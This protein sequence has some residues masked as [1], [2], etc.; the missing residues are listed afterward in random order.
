MGRSAVV[1]RFVMYSVCAGICCG[2]LSYSSLSG[3]AHA[4]EGRPLTELNIEELMEVEVYSASK[5]PQKISEAPSSVSIVTSDEIKKYGYRTL[6]EIL[7]SLRG[8]FVTSDRNYDYMGVRGF[9]RPGDYNT[10]VLLLVDGHRINDNI[11][12]QAF[13]GT[14]FPVD[15]DL[16]DR[17]EVIRGPGSSLYGSNAFF[18]VINVLTKKG[19]DFGG[20]EASGEAGSNDAYKARLSYGKSFENGFEAALSGSYYHSQGNRQLYYKE[21]D[22]PATNNGIAENADSGRFT[23]LFGEL[24][25]N[26]FTLQ[27]VYSDRKKFVPTAS[28]G[29][30]FNDNRFFTRE[31]HFYVDLKYEHTFASG[32][33]LVSRLSYNYHKYNGDYPY[34]LTEPGGIPASV[35][36]KDYAIG[37]WWGGEVQLIKTVFE[38]HKVVVGAEYRDNFEQD[39]GNYDVEV[40]LDD[41]RHSGVLAFYAEDEFTIFRNLILNAGVR[42]DHYSTFG[43]TTNPRLAIVYSPL[44]KTTFKL[45][46]GSAFR[47]PNAVE[48]YYK[49]GLD[50]KLNP[51]LKPE[52]IRT[53]EL[54]CEQLIG[55]NLRATAVG[56][57][58]KIKDLITLTVDPSDNMF[59]Y[60]NIGGATAKGLEFELEGKW[61]NGLSGRVS[62]TLQETKDKTTGERLTN[63]PEHLAKLN[64][65]VPLLKDKILVGLEEQFM[66]KRK[67]LK[68]DY[69]NTS[70]LTNVTLFSRNLVKNMEASVSVYNLFDY[71]YGDP[72]SEEHRQDII[73]QDGRTFRFKLT[74][75]F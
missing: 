22:D 15:V 68:G 25:F 72:G 71:H 59:V 13:I 2:L 50:F 37:K 4:E 47:A 53:Y 24:S 23:D 70:Y 18:A 5:F 33:G 64:V 43:S 1:E 42:Y 41:H 26:G 55:D 67:T 56:F 58:N 12:D 44:E 57:Y 32:L 65:T 48:L 21:F 66:S 11:Y 63:S 19:R 14:D 8:F 49:G 36:N 38:R 46:Y 39:Q 3:R 10:R 27:S 69:T 73:E 61:E 6:A 60:E 52:T 30:I 17:V 29:T 34:D 28:F 40:Y 16:I 74:Y 35:L 75:R 20:A 31:R 7:R 9:L 54:V 45:I 51:N 62:Y